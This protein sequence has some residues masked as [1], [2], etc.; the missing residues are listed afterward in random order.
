MFDKWSD[1]VDVTN[2]PSSRLD[3]ALGVETS[4][5]RL[6]WEG[7]WLNKMCRHT[8]F[9]MDAVRKVSQIAWQG[10]HQAT[11]DHKS[12]FHHVP[13]DPESWT[14]FG[15]CWKGEYY[16]WTVLCLGWCSSPYFYHTLSS[17]VG[18]YLRARDVP[19]LVWIDDFYLTYPRAT[20]E[21]A[22]EQQAIPPEAAIHLALCVFHRAGYFM[23]LEKC[24]LTPTTRL[25]YLAIVCYSDKCRFE[26]PEDMLAKL[27]ATLATAIESQSI[28]FAMLQKLAGKCTSMS[29]AVPAAN[30]YTLYMYKQI[31]HLQRTG[32]SRV[33]ATIRVA[34]NGILRAEM[35]KW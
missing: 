29:V 14:Y 13:I 20:R 7:R 11:L 9:S 33:S 34:P 31:R 2:Q 10:A 4:K 3:L 30:L 26:V 5:P 15:L 1:I 21:E 19:V 23:S 12:G 24:V 25:V 17:A 27:E 16:V 18:Q 6:F 28:T 35:D 8:P 32:R 22:Q